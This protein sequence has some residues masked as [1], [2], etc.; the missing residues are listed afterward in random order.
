MLIRGPIT[1]VQTPC[2]RV[3]RTLPDWFGHEAS[4]L[5]YAANTAKLATF[6][7]EDGGQVVGFMSLRQ[8]F[9]ASW[10]ID[11]IAVEGPKRN[12]GIGQALHAQAEL[13]L[14]SQGAQLLQVKTLA[15][16]HPSV[17]YAQ[18]RKFYESLGY[19]P[20]EVF[21]TLWEADLPVL[22][23]VKVLVCAR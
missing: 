2:E 22:L 15:E 21:P 20:L 19:R 5:E 1:G 6:V 18:T 10:E 7:A 3:L 16:S 9:A 23:L 14:C 12:H 11:C 17:A 13:W 8:H 4:L